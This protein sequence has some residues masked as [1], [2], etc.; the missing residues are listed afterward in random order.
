MTGLLLFVVAHMLFI[1]FEQQMRQLV[2]GS[3]AAALDSHLF[4][5]HNDGGII[6]DGDGLK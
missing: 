2:Q 4:V 1:K 6:V 3:E 5:E